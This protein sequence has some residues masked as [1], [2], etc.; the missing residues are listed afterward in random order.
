MPNGC[1]RLTMA[2][3][4]VEMRYTTID[5]VNLIEKKNEEILYFTS[6]SDRE[7][8]NP[9]RLELGLA[10]GIAVFEWCPQNIMRKTGNTII[11]KRERFY[12]RQRPNMCVFVLE[13][14]DYGSM[15]VGI[16]QASFCVRA[17]TCAL[18][19]HLQHKQSFAFNQKVCHD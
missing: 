8:K 15:C 6:Q 5:D 1:T 2:N 10:Y 16:D 3:K 9:N 13:D 7:W 17:H 18:L 12:K 11:M 14:H 4:R 19:Q